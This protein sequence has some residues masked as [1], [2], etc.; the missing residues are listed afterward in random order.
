MNGVKNMNGGEWITFFR[1]SS[2][3][4]KWIWGYKWN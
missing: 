4:K 1:S 3:P 2:L